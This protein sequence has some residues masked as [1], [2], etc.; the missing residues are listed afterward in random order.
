MASNNGN[1]QPAV[2]VV[3]NPLGTT[4]VPNFT[5]STQYTITIAPTPG[6]VSYTVN[7]S[8]SYTSGMQFS[9]AVPFTLT[10]TYQSGIYNGK[11]FTSQIWVNDT[12]AYSI[13]FP[14]PPATLGVTNT[15]LHNWNI[16]VGASP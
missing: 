1:T 6:A 8:T 11:T 16:G 12:N 2:F 9:G 14:Q 13:V 10:I 4:V 7:G 5:D 3:L 15:A